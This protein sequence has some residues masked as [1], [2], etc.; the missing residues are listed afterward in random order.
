[1]TS[2]QQC[3]LPPGALLA[4][5]EKSNHYTDCF[6]VD[7]AAQVSIAKFVTAFYTSWLFKLER[8]ILHFA[9]NKPSTDVEAE[10]VAIGRRELFAAW[11]VEDRMSKE[12]L[13]CAL[14]GRT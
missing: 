14:G 2:V 8:L 4:R 5:Y 12:L 10:Q 6:Y 7:I 9:F 11:S 3:K 13:M 1:M